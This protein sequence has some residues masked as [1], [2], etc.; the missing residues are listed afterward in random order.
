MM[1]NGTIPTLTLIAVSM[2]G[3]RANKEAQVQAF[4]ADMNQVTS[5][6]VQMVNRNP[7]VR[8]ID[9]AQR[10]L[11]EK[12]IELK[13]RYDGLKQLAAADL[14]S[15]AFKKLTETMRRDIEAVGDLQIVHAEK[16]VSD[17]TFA[18]KMNKL[19]SDYSSIYGV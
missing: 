5:E 6:I 16:T 11:D 17:E 14:S 3:C 7:T 1:R 9:E 8:G 13:T 18:R 4:I 12:K 15:D 10:I 19:Y 2:A